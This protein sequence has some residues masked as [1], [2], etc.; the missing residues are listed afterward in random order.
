M[1]FSSHRCLALLVALCVASCGREPSFREQL[2]EA[3]VLES[4]GRFEEARA[5]Y[6]H[7]AMCD[8][9]VPVFA[10]NCIFELAYW[11]AHQNF[12]LG[13][14]WSSAALYGWRYALIASWVSR[15][16]VPLATRRSIVV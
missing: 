2:A 13:N 3:R 7:D 1:R 14:I 5:L 11:S 8:C 12:V 4:E 6:V 9:A 16:I 10:W 15:L